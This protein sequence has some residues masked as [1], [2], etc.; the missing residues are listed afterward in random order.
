MSC[1]IAF[2]SISMTKMVNVFNLSIGNTLNAD[3]AFT[4]RLAAKA[5]L[6]EV[7]CVEDCDII[8]AF[9]PIS[10]RTGVDVGEALQRIPDHKPAILVMIHHTYDTKYIVPEN[11]NEIRS[12]VLAVDILFHERKGL[13]NCQHNDLAVDTVLGKLNPQQP[14]WHKP[15]KIWIFI[16][17]LTEVD[18]VEDCDIILAFFPISSRTGVDIGEA[19]QRIPDHKSAILVMIHHTY[20]PNYIVPENRN[21]IRSDVLAVDILFHE[22]KGLLNCQR[23]DLA[24]DTVLGKLNPQQ[25][26]WPKPQKIWIPIVILVSVILFLFFSQFGSQFTLPTSRL[27]LYRDAS[28]LLGEPEPEPVPA[29]PTPPYPPLVH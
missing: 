2:Y 3:K 8:L 5:F 22:K 21:E 28:T 4:E 12:D 26:V 15:R 29:H 25:P 17:S 6:T 9:C 1:T 24:V 13:L 14:V 10:S 23:N 27:L 16:R 19:L 20:D 11:R 7:E 18:H